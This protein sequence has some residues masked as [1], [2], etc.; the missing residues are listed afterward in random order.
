MTKH[1]F[2]TIVTT[3]AVAANSRGKGMGALS[4]LCKKSPVAMINTLL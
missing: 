1:L 3:T 4:Q 2:A